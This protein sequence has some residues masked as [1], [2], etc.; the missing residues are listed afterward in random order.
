MLDALSIRVILVL[1]IV[2]LALPV[3]VSCV[4]LCILVGVILLT[5]EINRF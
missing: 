1:G 5:I 4:I 3:F 2:A